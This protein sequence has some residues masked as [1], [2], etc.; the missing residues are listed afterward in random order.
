M[1]SLLYHLISEKSI[2]KQKPQGM[3]DN[4]EKKLYN[5]KVKRKDREYR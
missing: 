1:I 4:P 5:R 2:P 3:I